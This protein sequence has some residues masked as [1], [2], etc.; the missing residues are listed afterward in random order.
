MQLGLTKCAVAHLLKGRVR[1]R[2]EVILPGGRQVLAARKG[3]PYKYLG[4]EQVFEPDLTTVQDRLKKLYLWRVR[5]IWSSNLNGR[6]KV[7]AHN[8]GLVSMPRLCS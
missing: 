6:N 5:T 2:G 4:I 3:N 8:A 7:L 1:D